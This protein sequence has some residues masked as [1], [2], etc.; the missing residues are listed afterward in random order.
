[1]NHPEF[2]NKEIRDFFFKKWR[3]TGCFSL[4]SKDTQKEIYWG[5]RVLKK[6]SSISSLKHAR[7]SKKT[8]ARLS[9]E[10]RNSA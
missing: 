8:P 10:A 6:K 4:R 7:P 9:S 3:F 5:E 2:S 1:M